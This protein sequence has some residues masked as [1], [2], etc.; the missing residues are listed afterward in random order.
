MAER[1]RAPFASISTA[2]HF[3][4]QGWGARARRNSTHGLVTDMTVLPDTVRQLRVYI[5]EYFFIFFTLVQGQTPVTP[6]TLANTKENWM[7]EGPDHVVWMDK[8]HFKFVPSEVAWDF[9]LF[10]WLYVIVL[11]LYRSSELCNA[12]F[13]ITAAVWGEFWMNWTPPRL[14]EWYSPAASPHGFKLWFWPKM[15]LF[16]LVPDTWHLCCW[17][18]V[19]Y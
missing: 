9:H 4:T 15:S 10:F 6:P 18:V 19:L 2:T 7:E 14:S 12:H 11:V 5:W 13:T 3:S 17:L 16:K 8:D 1:P